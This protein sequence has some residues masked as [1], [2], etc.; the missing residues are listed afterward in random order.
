M[1]AAPRKIGLVRLSVLASALALASMAHAENPAETA[2]AWGLMGTWAAD[3]RLPPSENNTYLSYVAASG[4][5]LTHER[6]AGI[7]RDV[8]DVVRT[9]LAV[10][11]IDLVVYFPAAAQTR[12]LTIA[13]SP[14]G[15]LRVL[16]DAFVNTNEFAVRDGK[17]GGT[18]EDTPWQSKCR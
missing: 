1:P 9:T 5:R 13:K 18:G 2:A 8:A 3:C 7:R 15:R 6:D 11:G 12:Q 10:G 4:G 16:A 17:V 14:D